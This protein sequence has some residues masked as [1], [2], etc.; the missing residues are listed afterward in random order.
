MHRHKVKRQKV[1]T[2]KC[3]CLCCSRNRLGWC[4]PAINVSSGQGFDEEQPP[5]GLRW[6]LLGLH[7]LRGKPPEPPP[8]PPQEQRP[9]QRQEPPSE[10]S[11]TP[12]PHRV[13]SFRRR[14]PRGRRHERRRRRFRQTRQSRCRSR[15]CR[16]RRGWS[17][18]AAQAARAMDGGY[19]RRRSGVAAEPLPAPSLTHSP[20]RYVSFRRRRP[21]GRCR[22]R[23]RRS[24]RQVSQSRFQ[25]S[26][27][28][29]RGGWNRRRS[30]GQSD[31]RRPPPAQERSRR[32]SSRCRRRSRQNRRQSSCPRI[33][34]IRRHLRRAPPDPPPPGRPAP[35][36]RGR[37]PRLGR[38]GPSRHAVPHR[39]PPG[40]IPR[41]RTRTRGRPRARMPRRRGPAPPPGEPPP[42][43]PPLPK[44]AETH[45]RRRASEL[46]GGG[47]RRVPEIA[48]GPR[49][50]RTAQ[51]GGRTG[52]DGRRT[53]GDGLTGDGRM[54]PFFVNAIS[55]NARSCSK[56]FSVEGR[57]AW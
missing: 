4:V 19:R 26:G 13:T 14:R 28:R 9:E 53:T 18:R 49:R 1:T 33:P 32:R 41:A 56:L 51:R 52:G 55:E 8:E 23:R 45:L 54:C 3:A 11:P 50:P 42:P 44:P 57:R 10:P 2:A 17:R 40:P 29:R 7:L 39:P 22:K 15:G 47:R 46:R 21:R 25:S 16:F 43:R 6:T 38:P 31:G 30:G 20:N 24:L 35:R 27:C 48:K 12:P 34:S 37:L 5:Q 36:R